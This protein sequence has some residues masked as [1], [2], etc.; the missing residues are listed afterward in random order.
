MALGMLGRVSLARADLDLAGAQLASS[1]EVFG[2]ID[3]PLRV[4]L[5]LVPLGWVT[6]ERGEL[7]QGAGAGGGGR[8]GVYKQLGEQGT[9][10]RS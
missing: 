3:F 2:S 8:T 4:A 1:Q 6:L 10:L 7:A 9:V 5:I